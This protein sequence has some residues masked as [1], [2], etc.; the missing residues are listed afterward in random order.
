MMSLAFR[1]CVVPIFAVMAMGVV[2]LTC[3]AANGQ[4]RSS[5]FVRVA[6]SSD[7]SPTNNP[8]RAVDGAN[9]TFSLTADV[10]G[11]YWSAELGRP[12]L[13]TRLE[14][15]NRTAPFDTEMSG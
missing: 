3:V 6:Q 8:L 7:A 4:L 12:Y 5:L 1:R 2:A 9:A 11:S 15:V 13:L 10:P 14:V